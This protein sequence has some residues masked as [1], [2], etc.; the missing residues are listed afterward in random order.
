MILTRVEVTD[1]LSIKGTLPIDMDKKITIL[2]GSNDHG[3]SNILRAIQHLNDDDPISEVEANWDAEDA[4]QWNPTKSP[5]ISYVF[6]LTPAER[7]EWKSAVE[8]TTQEAADR[9]AEELLSQD[10]TEDD[11]QQDDEEEESSPSRTARPASAAESIFRPTTTLGKKAP[12]KVEVEDDD[13][14]EDAEDHAGLPL[15]NI[16]TLD[17]AATSITIARTGVEGAL[18]FQGVSLKLLPKFIKNFLEEKKPRVELFEFLR[19]TLQDSATKD[20]ISTDE[21]EFLQG[22]FFQAGLDPLKSDAL[23][24]QNDRTTRK[25]DVA[26]K[27]LDTN[28]RALWGQGTEL[29]FHLRHKDKSIEFLADDP[30]IKSRTT[31]MSTRSAGVTQFFRVSMVLYARRRKSPANSY[32]YLFDEPG[33]LLHP[34]GQRDLLQVFEQLASEN[35][36]AY[37][38]HSLFLL[39]QNFPERHRL[40][41]KDEAGTKVDQKPYR[42]NWKFATDALGVYLTSNILFS[43]KV[44]L[45][46]GDSD[47]MYLYEL[48]RQLNR[49][50]DLDVDLNSL[51][52]MSFYDYQNLRFLL[53]VFKR[54]GQDASLF[55]VVD[56][57]EAGEGML[58]RVNELCKKHSI[59]THKLP[60]GRSVEDYCLF[61]EEFLQAVTQTLKSAAEFEGKAVPKDLAKRVQELWEEHKSSDEKIEKRAKSPDDNEQKKQ[62]RTTGRWFKDASAKLIDDEASKVVLARTYCQPSREIAAPAPN[63]EKLK[64][65]KLLCQTIATKLSLPQVKAEKAIEVPH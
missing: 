42:Q 5:S 28:L 25:L 22:V 27:K 17:A 64:E 51:G 1:F 47:P 10:K 44:L 18:T 4:E 40:I 23:F 48:F 65:A 55:V 62:K 46:E 37:A 39:N 58:K 56:G 60:E 35:Q 15:L 6:A 38:T 14:E 45:V 59:A 54:E 29:H 20:T 52:I 63:R 26:S 7:K 41:T 8:Q 19:G 21:Y 11:E 33:V 36:I 43:N 24:Q 53:Q 34:Q 31:R 2:L 3:K 57:D 50:G 32:I 9:A 61:E 49:T 12:L 30:S 16:E 13:E